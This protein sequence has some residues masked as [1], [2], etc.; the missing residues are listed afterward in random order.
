[1]PAP[2]LRL[3]AG[4]FDLST[5][6]PGQEER[7]CVTGVTVED[8]RAST[9]HPGLVPGSAGR[10]RDLCGNCNRNSPAKHRPRLK[11][12]TAQTVQCV[13]DREIAARNELGH[14]LTLMDSLER[15][16]DPLRPAT[17]VPATEE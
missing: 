9:R 1:M 11:K 14:R 16:A 4:P 8:L 2:I 10:G 12:F 13:A 5:G 17:H 7:A 6:L 3:W 15:T